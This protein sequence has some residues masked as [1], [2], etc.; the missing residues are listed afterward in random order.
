LAVRFAK[1][2]AFL[3][4]RVSRFELLRFFF[5]VGMVPASPTTVVSN[6]RA[7]EGRCRVRRAL[8][9]WWLRRRVQR[10]LRSGGVWKPEDIARWLS[11]PL[12][13]VYVVLRHLVR[14]KKVL[15]TRSGYL[16][17]A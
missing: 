6:E 2:V 14:S 4:L 17:A 8:R 11:A 15:A 5:V 7:S 12:D 10:V 13:E 3:D 1:N 9:R 16:W